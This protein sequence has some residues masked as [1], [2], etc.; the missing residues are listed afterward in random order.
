M[1]LLSGKRALI[2]GAARGIGEACAKTFA[3]NG[4][5]EIFI[6]DIDIDKA[7]DVAEKIEL[8]T[9]ARCYAIR[10]D[11]SKE[12]EILKVFDVIKKKSSK[13]D[14]LVNCAGLCSTIDMFEL[15]MDRWDLTLDVNLKGSFLFSREAMKMMKSRKYGRIINFTSVAGQIGG[16]R[17]DVAYAAS[18]AGIACL[19]KSLAK[20]VAK[21][22][23]TVN[24]ISPGVIKTD[25]TA[26]FETGEN[27]IPMGR[28]GE[29]SDIADVVMFLAGDLSRYI[30][31]ACIDVNGGM[32]MR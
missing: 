22:G 10:A 17:T 7:N 6:V 21:E 8:E 24:S 5:E 23:I 30:T 13:L 19:T 12:E 3:D 26:S 9:K 28:I 14:I 20:N 32:Y 25:M 27:E 15:S 18:K 4:A 2:T 29:S 31:G 16:I 1:K 11:I